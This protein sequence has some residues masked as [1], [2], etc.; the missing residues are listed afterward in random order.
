MATALE[1][2]RAATRSVPSLRE[3]SA[4]GFTLIEILISLFI[5]ALVFG[6]ALGLVRSGLADDGLR[7]GSR[8]LAAYAKTA[9]SRAVSENRTYEIVLDEHGFLLRARG[10]FGKP[11]PPLLKLALPDSISLLVRPWGSDRWAH[12]KGLI[13]TFMPTGL[14]SPERVR[15]EQDS[16]WIEEEFNPLTANRQDERFFFP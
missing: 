12:P 4:E 9:R 8:Q 15:F 16:A 1:I 5:V 2:G 13:W 11:A 10:D 14:C 7:A 3:R 6:A